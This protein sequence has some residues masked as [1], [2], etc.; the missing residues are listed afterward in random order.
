MQEDGEEHHRVLQGV[1]YWSSAIDEILRRLETGPGGLTQAEAGARLARIGPNSLG[2][3]KR[4]GD[5]ALLAAQFKSPIILILVFAAIMGFFLGQRT[6]ALIILTIIVS[7]GLLGF[8]QER[9]ATGAVEAL[10][11][12]VRIQAS[13]IRDGAEFEV[14]VQDVVPGDVVVLNA[15]DIV[16]GDCRLLEA[17]DLY[18]DEATLTGE[19]FPVEK[20][21]GVVPV[22]TPLGQ[23][24]N[25]LF[26]GTHVVSGT[27]RALVVL[28][29][30]DTEFSQVRRRIVSARPET[31]FERGI[32]HFGYLLLEITLVLVFAIF[33]INVALSRPVLDSCLFSMA[34]AV[35]LTPQLL[36]A[37]ISI[38]L[39]HG[40]RRMAERH[41]IVK[42]LASIENFGSMDVLCSDKTGTLTEGIVRVCD[43]V[44][45]HGAPSEKVRLYA[46]LNARYESGFANPIDAAIRVDRIFDLSGY[47]KLDEIPYDFLRKRLSILV[48]KDG[49]PLLVTKGALASVLEVCTQAETVDGQLVNLSDAR[50][51]ITR[52][53]EE[54]GAQGYRTLGI[55]SRGFDRAVALSR[56]H[57]SEMIFV[58]FLV[59]HDPPKS[60]IAETVV[61]LRRLGVTLKLVTGDN[62]H[63]AES[64][65]RAVG[66]G[67]SGILT[68]ADL[69][70]MSDDALVHQIGTTS[71][72]AEVEPNQ[73]ERV[74][75]ALKKRGNV[76]GYLGDGINDAT[77]LHAADV[78]LSVDS[79]VDVAKDSAD[80]VLLDKDLNVLVDGIRLGRIAF[81]N[82][83]KYIFIA[84]SANFGNMFSMAGASLFLPYLP[85][86]PKQILLLNLLTDLPE[87]AIATDR[88]DPEMVERPHRWNISAI[89]RFMVVFGL[90][91][92]LFDYAT[93][94]LLLMVLGVSMVP[95]RTAWFVE[96]L[97]SATMVVLVVRTRRPFFA[98]LPGKVLL[99]NTLAVIAITIIV[100]YTPLAH[101][102][103]FGPL[104]GRIVLAMAAV[105]ALYVAAAELVKRWYYQPRKH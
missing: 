47:R 92:S 81:A 13:V 46:F 40:A 8:W 32:R 103:G 77:A 64:V 41:V 24:S 28:N 17:K 69:H 105:C 14:F 53:Y 48:E 54:L 91:S 88:V 68:G 25:S 67:A 20:M 11:A 42:R 12:R 33:A 30:S 76:V 7:S 74:L 43:G 31:E 19:T 51:E 10:L 75:L 66:L 35:G 36:P 78:G 23:R 55:A 21:A 79:A 83:L 104:P 37:I 89:R 70:R 2:P 45:F 63:V 26:Q 52:H 100:P 57:E 71:I 3:E 99:V 27:A 61:Q 62:R 6:D 56:G 73:K 50:G 5:L 1:P 93:F 97:I 59:L 98:S 29:G 86:L 101:L 94:T 65:G 80:I 22:E 96:S 58:G 72:F 38:N 39:A 95:F 4:A 16:P 15:G 84:T 102:W 87:M 44:D 49:R 85:L 60:G 90:L 18:A 82:T 34:L 9:A